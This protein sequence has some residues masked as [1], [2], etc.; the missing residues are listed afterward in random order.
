[1]RNLDITDSRAKLD[2]YRRVGTLGGGGM[3]ELDP[4]RDPT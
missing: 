3:L 2:V 1:M 4:D